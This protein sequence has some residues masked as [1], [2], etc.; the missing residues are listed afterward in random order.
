MLN[1]GGDANTDVKC[2][3]ALKHWVNGDSDGTVNG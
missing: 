1:F 2:E 3:Q